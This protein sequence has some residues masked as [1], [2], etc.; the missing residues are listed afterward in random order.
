MELEF[1][2]SGSLEPRS[3]LSVDEDQCKS[4]HTPRTRWAVL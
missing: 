2:L 3:R 4:V 1:S